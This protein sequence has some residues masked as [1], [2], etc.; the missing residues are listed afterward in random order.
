ML[1]DWYNMLLESRG[2]KFPQ[3]INLP[4]G[5]QAQFMTDYK[6]PIQA[7]YQ[8]GGKFF[9]FEGKEVVKK[10]VGVYDYAP[11]ATPGQEAGA[12]GQQVA[13]GGVKPAPAPT[14]VTPGVTPQAAP[15]QPQQQK[16]A[17]P[18]PMNPQAVKQQ[19]AAIGPAATNIANSIRQW[20]VTHPQHPQKGAAVA[21]W[22]AW[23]RA[24]QAFE[25]ELA[26]MMGGRPQS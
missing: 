12:N 20:I 1:P 19:A 5:G 18:A 15:V 9:D 8:G 26:G 22:N 23:V 24:R 11:A 2:R 16:P 17:A 14:T 4:N 21:A 10:G 7:I 6:P 3:F 13:G 25:K